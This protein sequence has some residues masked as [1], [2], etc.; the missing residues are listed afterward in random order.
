[1]GVKL[2]AAVAAAS[3]FSSFAIGQSL[4]DGPGKDVV[5]T[6]C[7]LCHDAGAAVIGKQWT[8]TQWEL[9]ET[10]MLQEEQQGECKSTGDGIRNLRTSR[11]SPRLF[12]LIVGR[13]RDKN[14]EFKTL[15]DVKKFP[16][17]DAAKVDARKDLIV[18]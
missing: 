15:D 10:E 11:R 6:V 14:G 2:L 17:L 18:F 3:L 8:R 1:V 16:G 13:Y 7:S 4:P 12:D 5:Q 9:K